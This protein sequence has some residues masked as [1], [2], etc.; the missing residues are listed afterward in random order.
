MAAKTLLIGD[1]GGT[2]ARFALGDTRKPGFTELATFKCADFESVES[3][4]REYLDII[5]APPP[6]LSAWPVRAP[7][8]TA[9][10]E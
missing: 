3:A 8:S 9:A 10:S 2:N 5:A 4:I 1:I 7:L 6:V